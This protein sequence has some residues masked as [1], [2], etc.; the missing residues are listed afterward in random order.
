MKEKIVILL[1]TRSDGAKDFFDNY[2][3]QTRQVSCI[4]MQDTNFDTDLLKVIKW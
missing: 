1:R 2:L 4:Q 3:L